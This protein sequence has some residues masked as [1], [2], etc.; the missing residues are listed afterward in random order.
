MPWWSQRPSSHNRQRCCRCRRYI[1]YYPWCTG[2]KSEIST[3]SIQM[4]TSEWLIFYLLVIK[5]G[6][7]DKSVLSSI[8]LVF[9]F[10]LR[11]GAFLSCGPEPLVAIPKWVLKVWDI[12]VYSLRCI[13]PGHRPQPWH[14]GRLIQTQWGWLPRPLQRR[15]KGQLWWFA[16]WRA[17]DDDP[18]EKVKVVEDIEM[19]WWEWYYMELRVM[20]PPL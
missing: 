3:K 1:C 14:R 19:L 10:V 4:A 16:L 13:W 6:A 9:T 12:D 18:L 8:V 2:K 20:K 15:E 5:L 11:F 7:L 17:W